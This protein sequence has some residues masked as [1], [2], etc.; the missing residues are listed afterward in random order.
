MTSVKKYVCTPLSFVLFWFLLSIYIHHR[1]E[2]FV[3]HVKWMLKE[4]TGQTLAVFINSNR[5]ESK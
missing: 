2:G 3:F 5:G 4:L 1:R